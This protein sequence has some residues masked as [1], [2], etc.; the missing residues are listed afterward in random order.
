MVLLLAVI[1]FLHTVVGPPL[2]LGWFYGIG[3]SGVALLLLYE[4]AIVRPDDLTRINMAFFNVNAVVS[5]GLFLI[6]TVDVFVI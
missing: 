3:V 6:A 4:H 1:P 5:I 2:N